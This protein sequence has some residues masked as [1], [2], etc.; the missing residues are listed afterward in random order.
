VP[1]DCARAWLDSGVREDEAYL[2]LF[3]PL[4]EDWRAR[5]Q[6]LVAAA[7]RDGEAVVAFLRRRP[8][9]AQAWIERAGLLGVR[10]GGR[11]RGEYLL[12]RDDVLQGRK[13]ADAACRCAW[14]IEFWDRT[15]GVTLEYLPEGGCYEIPLRALKVRGLNNLWAVGKCLSADAHAQASARIAGC[16]WAM[17]AAAGSAA[18]QGPGAWD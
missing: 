2:K 1:A 6:E 9:F 7:R 3:V 5:E 18:A 17:G 15:A 16:C 14:P 11:I 8:E 13:F 12:T 10:D 4:P